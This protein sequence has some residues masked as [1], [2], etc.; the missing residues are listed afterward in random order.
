[1]IN[2][3]LIGS[4]KFGSAREASRQPDFMS[5][6]LTISHTCFPCLPSGR[7]LVIFLLWAEW[8]AENMEE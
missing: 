2:V 5:S 8:R 3:M 7:T 6:C 4:A 1:M